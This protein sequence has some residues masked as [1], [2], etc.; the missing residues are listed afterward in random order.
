LGQALFKESA[1]LWKKRGSFFNLGG[2]LRNVGNSHLIAGA[3]DEAF[4]SYAEA[5][6]YRIGDTA[7]QLAGQ[8]HPLSA[9]QLYRECLRFNEQLGHATAIA[10]TQFNVAA[11]L[12]SLGRAAEALP[13][14]R[15]ASETFARHGHLLLENT[16]NLL[17][18][19][20]AEVKPPLK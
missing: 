1:D 9:L 17:S 4:R 14:I 7:T 20:E 10:A 13:H 6:A 15:E 19:C 8:S 11:L 5:V 12:L 18:R 16:R 3:L 2:T